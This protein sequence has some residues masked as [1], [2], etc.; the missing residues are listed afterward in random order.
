MSA[1]YRE[2]VEFR[3]KVEALNE[4]RDP[5]I[6]AAAKELAARLLSKVKK[7]T[8]V[9]VYPHKVGGNLRRNWEVKPIR[10]EGN[11]YIVEI[12]NPTEYAPYVEYG[13]RTSN[14]TGWVPGRFMMTIS[15]KEIKAIAPRVLEAKLKKW[16][17][18]AIQ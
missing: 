18:E 17:S 6:E 12:A 15:E 1:D 2:L 14:H 3:K 7:R 5:F 8:P 10:K 4:S 13:H 16:L 11:V 9:G